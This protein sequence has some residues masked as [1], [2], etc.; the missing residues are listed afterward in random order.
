VKARESHRFGGL[1][2]TADNRTL[3]ARDLGGDG[4]DSPLRAAR[5]SQSTGMRIG[6]TGCVADWRC[7]LL[8]LRWRVAPP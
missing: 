4:A 5:G 8:R 7:D 1:L 2:E 3:Y 6:L